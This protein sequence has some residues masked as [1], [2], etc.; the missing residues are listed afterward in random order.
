[1]KV[2]YPEISFSF[3]PH[4][5]G[6][7]KVKSKNKNID[8]YFI[9]SIPENILKPSFHELNI[10]NPDYLREIFKE[11]LNK[12]KKFPSKISILLPEQSTRVFLM[13]FDSLPSKKEEIRE[14]LLWRIKKLIP[15]PENG[16][17][18]AWEKIDSLDKI[19]A[20]AFIAS[21]KVISQY[22]DFFSEF[23]L[24]VGLIE[25][26]IFPL[27][28]MVRKEIEGNSLLINIEN[29]F[30]TILGFNE[31]NFLIYRAKSFSLSDKKEILKEIDHTLKFL[32]DKLNIDVNS[33][34]FRIVDSGD[35]T[36]WSEVL[37]ENFSIPIVFIDP[38]PS[39]K[40]DS[41]IGELTF[42]EKQILS[43]L[44]GQT[45]W[46]NLDL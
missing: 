31:S 27:F 20:I 25:S 43:P 2:N 28:D 32:K 18:L 26:S 22:E 1:M 39:I 13:N 5:I 34:I 14:L 36:E 45:L 44:I 24:Q 17:R 33:L 3:L 19:K 9:R 41:S 21:E 4:Y 37:K 8:S 38:F 16:V 40:F 46:R 10:L 12:M 42:K 11:E 29:S 6:G 30:L 7:I 35:E 23:K 15:L